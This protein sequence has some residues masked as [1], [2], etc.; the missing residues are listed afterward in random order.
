MIDILSFFTIYMSLFFLITIFGVS[1]FGHWG[2]SKLLIGAL[3]L[4]L[5]YKFYNLSGLNVSNVLV[6]N[7]VELNF[8][9]VLIVLQ[10][11]T[12]FLLPDTRQS[13]FKA[14]LSCLMIVGLMICIG[15]TSLLTFFLA[16]QLATYSFLGALAMDKGG[17]VSLNSLRIFMKNEFY[18]GFFLLFLFF[19]L[20][21]TGG[22]G[23]VDVQIQSEKMFSL[24]GAMFTCYFLSKFGIFPFHSNETDIIRTTQL[25][26]SSFGL[27]LNKAGL[28][29]ATFKIYKVLQLNMNPEHMDYLLFVF[30]ILGIVTILYAGLISTW[31]KNF[32]DSISYLYVVLMGLLAF[33]FSIGINDQIRELSFIYVVISGLG[34][35]LF[36]SHASKFL[37]KSGENVCYPAK[38][39]PIVWTFLTLGILLGI[40][41]FPGYE[42]KVLIMK[43]LVVNKHIPDLLASCLTIVFGI[44]II[45][46]FKI[47]SSS[48]PNN[49]TVLKNTIGLQLYSAIVL[50]G[51]I[52]FSI[53]P[54]LLLNSMK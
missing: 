26:M 37:D 8:F 15:S 39:L 36:V 38:A 14:V 17:K 27:V 12:F 22:L 18:N 50:L 43:A 19:Y 24:S 2:I 41:S 51:L 46:F 4:V 45:K 13:F 29:F 11:V 10:V 21:A 40:P 49:Y 23:I 52:L 42:I 33:I 34:L 28:L 53:N 30:R 6:M 20:L 1:K 25:D 48:Y 47:E 31:S 54:A 5:L 7:K 3:Q 16:S 32:F 44:Q 9:S 35:V